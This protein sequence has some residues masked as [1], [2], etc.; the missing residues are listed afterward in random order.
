MPVMESVKASVNGTKAAVNLYAVL[1]NLEE[2]CRLD[3]ASI[4]LIQGKLHTIRFKIRGGPAADLVIADGEVSMQE[5]AG[6]SSIV[7]YFRSPE[8][9][10]KMIEGKAN[11]IPLRGLTRRGFLTTDFTKLTQRLEYYLKPDDVLL[12]DPD[13]FAIHTRLLLN[14][15]AYAVAC[16]GNYDE[17]GRRIA[18][19]IPDG[20][21]SISIEES[22]QQVFLRALKGRLQAMKSAPA[23]PSAYMVFDTVQSANDVL[24]EKADVHELIVTERL[25]LK[26]ML[27]MIQH[28][29]DILAKVPQFV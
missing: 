16:I 4:A 2:L 19:R 27:P 25:K 23:A 17:I 20:V 21:I 1:R 11:P 18:A 29:N 28:M 5:P 24:S 14:T 3:P 26:G 6:A 13:Y 22:G 9:F 12:K 7:L 8:H 10:N 15:A